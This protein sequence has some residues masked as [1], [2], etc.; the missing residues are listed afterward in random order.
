MRLVYFLA[1]GVLNAAL[2]LSFQ[3]DELRPL[4]Q[5]PIVIDLNTLGELEEPL[6]FT[7]DQ[8]LESP[9]LYSDI[10]GYLD[11]RSRRLVQ[12]FNESSNSP[13]WI[14]EGD[15]YRFRL[16]GVKFMDITDHPYL[17]AL[18][19]RL[20]KLKRPVHLRR[21]DPSMSSPTPASNIGLIHRAFD[22]LNATHLK[23]DIRKLT[24][25]W[26]REYHSR[27]GAASSNWI[28]ESV[29]KVCDRYPD[30]FFII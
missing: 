20:Q 14:A 7:V 5:T 17:G 21:C 2:C 22:S 3:S 11:L 12:L 15:K 10:T 13:R 24:S 27:W 6:K 23:S 19:H 16:Q 8:L 4:A 18:N 25:F 9:E 1:I 28:Y 29:N 30:A 26:S